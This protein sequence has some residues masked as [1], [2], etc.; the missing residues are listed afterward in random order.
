MPDDHHPPGA[1][2]T[3]GQRR[4]QIL[5]RRRVEPFV[6]A[7][8]LQRQTHRLARRHR[9]RAGTFRRRAENQIGNQ[10]VI[11]D[12]RAHLLTA[13]AAAIDQRPVKILVT[14]SPVGLSVPQYQQCLLSHGATPLRSI[15]F[16]KRDGKRQRTSATATRQQ[17]YDTGCPAAGGLLESGGSSLA[18]PPHRSSCCR[19]AERRAERSAAGGRRRTSRQQ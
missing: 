11:L 13:Q 9:R 4:Q 18:A 12:P 17:R 5:D 15:W 3:I 10:L 8:R 14:G 2:R 6:P 16:E 7:H 1:L 19:R